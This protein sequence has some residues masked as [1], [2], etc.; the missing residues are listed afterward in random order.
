VILGALADMY[1]MGGRAPLSGDEVPA[2]RLKEAARVATAAIQRLTYPDGVLKESCDPAYDPGRPP[3]EAPAAGPRALRAGAG[4]GVHQQRPR[5]PYGSCD[6]DQLVF[7]GMFARHLGYLC[8]RVA[9][10][11]AAVAAIGGQDVLQGWRS[12]LRTNA[13][14]L[15]LNAACFDRELPLRAEADAPVEVAP[16]LLGSVWIGPCDQTGA[17]GASQASAVAL[18]SAAAGACARDPKP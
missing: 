7:K 3:A 2:A 4:K 11:A 14:T 12:F 18:L 16:A 6:G 15:W 1:A 8:A 10:D 5:D 13:E 17:A 9:G